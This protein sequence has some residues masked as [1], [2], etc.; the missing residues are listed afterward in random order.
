MSDYEVSV[1]T[2]PVHDTGL[3]REAG[4]AND[5]ELIAAAEKQRAELESMLTPEAGSVGR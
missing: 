3:G 1:H 5:A 2:F 4:Y